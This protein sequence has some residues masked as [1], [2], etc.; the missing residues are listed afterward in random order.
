MCGRYLVNPTG[1]QLASVFDLADVP[2][3]FAPRYNVAPSQEVIV[4]GQRPGAPHRT[5]AR[6]RWGLVPHFAESPKS[7]P[8]P[9]NAKAETVAT[10]PAFRASFRT[11]RCL[12]PVSGF[13][14]WTTEEGQKSPHLFR[15]TD[16]LP[17]QL[18][19]FAGIYDRWR[20]SPNDAPLDTCAVITTTANGVMKPVHDRM[21]VVLDPADFDRWLDPATPESVL[22]RLLVPCP[23]EWLTRCRVSPRVNS[24]RAEGAELAE[25]LGA[26]SGS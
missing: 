2:Q 14:E 18:G 9:V 7:G 15:F 12:I 10:N 25:P 1:D 23:E 21:P 24:A 26:Q 19:A 4:V 20:A 3:G 13:Y 11:R 8:R 17:A 6:M 22:R 16:A 5:A